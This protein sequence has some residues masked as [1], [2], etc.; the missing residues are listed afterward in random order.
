MSK[1]VENRWYVACVR[2][3]FRDSVPRVYRES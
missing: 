1:A 2:L 3:Q